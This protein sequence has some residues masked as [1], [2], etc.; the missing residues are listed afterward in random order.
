MDYQQN[1]QQNEP[2]NRINPF[3]V[4][5]IVCGIISIILCCTGI[6]SIPAGALGILFA[7]LTR[8]LGQKMSPHSMTGIIL[9]CAGIA[10]GSIMLIYTIFLIYT[11]PEYQEL[12]NETYEY[13]SDF[14][15]DIYGYDLESK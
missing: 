10:M 5:S 9:S 7:L 8:R 2:A 13:Y 14:Y 12:Y 4:A 6:L 3:S 15:S 1:N 11:D